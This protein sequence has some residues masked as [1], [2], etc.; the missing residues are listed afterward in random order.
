[1]VPSRNEFM[2]HSDCS[3]IG[4]SAVNEYTIDIPRFRLR[5]TGELA[6]QSKVFAITFVP[7]EISH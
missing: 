5:S 1:M 2:K 6:Q 7:R 3:E 4:T